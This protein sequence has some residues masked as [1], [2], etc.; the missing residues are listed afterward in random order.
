MRRPRL[1]DDVLA[2]PPI[3]PLSDPHV[4]E[5]TEEGSGAFGRWLIDRELPAYRYELDQYRHRQAAFPN[6]EGA[7]R[8]ENWHQIGN[9]RVTALASNDGTVQVYLNDRGGIFLNRG[10]ARVKHR[11][12][13]GWL[14]ELLETLQRWWRW[15]IFQLT[16]GYWRKPTAVRN[17]Y[18]P[19]QTERPPHRKTAPQNDFERHAYVGGYGY[20][21][22]G[23]ETWAT[24]YRY[25]PRPRPDD[26][27]TRRMF[28]MGYFET[29]L[30]YRNIRT[31]RQVYA[32]F[33]D[34]PVLTAEIRNDD[35]VLIADIEIENRGSVAI[36]LRYY[37]YW[38]INVYQLKAQ[39]VRTG[40][41]VV[42]NDEE[43]YELND[44]FRLS[45]SWDDTWPQ[46]RRALRFHQQPPD[47]APACSERSS[48]DWCPADIF[49]LDLS[50]PADA[51]A[52]SPD[53][54]YTDK[55]QFFGNG[56]AK[57]PDAIRQYRA[58]ETTFSLPTHPMPYCL[59]LRR[60]MRL[61]PNQPVHLRF[62][63]GA[64]RPGAN[65]DFMKK[66]Q[67]ASINARVDHLRETLQHWKN[68][69]AYFTA[70]DP[71]LQREMAWHTYN[72]LS[73]TVYQAYY[74]A[75]VVAQGSAYLYLHG[76]DG[77][78]RDQS[79]FTIPLTYLRPPLARET[80]QLIMG[81]QNIENEAALAYAFTGYGQHESAIIHAKPSDLDLFF[82]L[83]VAEYV[84]ATGHVDFL[85]EHADFYPR[86]APPIVD[87]QPCGTTVL[88]HMRLAFKHLLGKV[89]TG[90][91]DLIA[92]GDGD[93]SDGIVIESV[94]V[95]RVLAL[96]NSML[97]GESIPNS[98]MARYV[99]PLA[100]AVIDSR[101]HALAQGMRAFA[102]RLTE[103]VEHQWLGRWY[104]RA[105]LRN[106]LNLPLPIGDEKINL[107]SQP[108]AL[109]SRD[110]A[111]H[112]H[113]EALI[114]SIREYL[115]EGSFT[116]APTQAGGQVW[117]AISQLLTWGY[118]RSHPG[119]AWRSLNRNTFAAH[120]IVF[121]KVWFNI[122]TGPDATNCQDSPNP[123][124]TWVSPLT[125]MTDFPAMNANPDA[126]ALLALLR[127]AGIEPAPSGDGLIIAPQS[128]PERFILDLP[129][130]RLEV[131]PGSIGGAYHAIVD[132]QRTLYIRVPDRAAHLAA[133]VDG[134]PIEINQGS[135]RTIPL[136]LHLKT[137]QVVPFKVQWAT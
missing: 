30:T 43:R 37:E 69:V 39:M 6:S 35:P 90:E 113:A 24:A 31:T 117:P 115:D 59:I 135:D 80:L 47:D 9:D 45:M 12:S 20:L 108:W 63:Y 82:L 5:P 21:D 29:E 28:G 85:D 61:E 2:A 81:L 7:D 106:E 22:D 36:D 58:G 65:L 99:L 54:M 3:P 32:P 25:R 107:E 94:G 19:A 131:A 105:I 34:Q 67:D 77:V 132:G 71:V 46:P 83:A 26:V 23:S 103:A 112:G 89:G 104:R 137:D 75:H 62:A 4:F 84:A 10:E 49:L 73:A 15:L 55:V 96:S 101:D 18:A 74:G 121:P 60:D 52:T 76:L 16:T 91:N 51:P 100:A 66:Y 56:G 127:V 126:M 102:S 110:A 14:F 93:W 124:G 13:F 111:D 116:G 125:P 38:D 17:L 119:L 123:G 86:G 44:N 33:E 64:V 40:L 27:Q 57:R 122:W 41:P 95:G 50:D 120:A 109:I 48:F 53:E 79:L 97:N 1:R 130:L 11:G 134:Q 88:D 129:L 87:G 118:T 133:S 70:G 92:I 136:R 42:H 98:Q 72:L 8:R 128:P 114:K 78:P 68:Q